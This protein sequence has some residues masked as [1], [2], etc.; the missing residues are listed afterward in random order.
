MKD[1]MDFF[2]LSPSPVEECEEGHLSF[3][4]GSLFYKDHNTV[5]LTR[6]WPSDYLWCP[7]YVIHLVWLGEEEEREEEIRGCLRLLQLLLHSFH[8]SADHIQWFS[9]VRSYSVWGQS[10][11]VFQIPSLVKQPNDVLL[12]FSAKGSGCRTQLI[13]DTILQCWNLFLLKYKKSWGGGS[14]KAHSSTLQDFFGS[15]GCI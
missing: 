1:A 9:C 7:H 8:I 2:F 11:R 12:C 14:I 10:A 13:C 4:K 3:W 5:C 15:R 6:P